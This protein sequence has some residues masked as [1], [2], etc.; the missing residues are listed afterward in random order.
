MRYIYLVPINSSE[1]LYLQPLADIVSRTF[2]IATK[3][4]PSHFDPSFAFD[5]SRHQ[6][7]S[8]VLLSRLIDNIPNDAFK[9]LGVTDLDLYVPVLTFV[10][11]EAQL[12]GPC[13]VVSFHRLA[14]Q[15]Y[16]LPRNDKVLQERLEKEV[17][18][19]LGHT[20]G[21]VHCADY[22]CVMHTSTYAE[23]IELKSSRFCK[24]CNSLV[25]A[26]MDLSLV[27]V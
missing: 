20:F 26:R 10:F 21:L 3:I 2:S 12:D 19:E 5:T 23:E 13:A 1:Y 27:K 8:T 4:D 6:Y 16:G 9:M 25:H 15:F 14:N 18:H 11:G 22:E 7:N 24:I 17:I